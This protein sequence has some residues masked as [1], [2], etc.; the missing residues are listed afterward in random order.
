MLRLSLLVVLLAVPA[1]A[2]V[3]HDFQSWALFAGQ[4]NFNSS[5]RWYFEAQP[6]FGSNSTRLERLLVRPA[7]GLQ[8]NTF[9][10]LWAGYA[11]TP[12][13][14][15]S[16]G[17]EHRPFQQL[18]AEHPLGPVMLIN[19]TRFEQRFVEGV[20]APTIRL[21]HLLRAV[22]RFDGPTG[23]GLAASEEL[24]V[25]FNGPVSGFDQNRVFLGLNWKIG[26]L[27]L[28]LGYLNN[29]VRRSAP[30]PTGMNHTILLMLLYTVAPPS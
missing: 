13:F 10:S 20:N 11:W 23:L 16:F 30:A 4:G 27:Q 1:S 9:F 21:R 3:T 7:V 19:R 28:E 12:L 15:P 25:N 8:L 29:V 5:V 22:W 18:L 26:G 17:N 14:S 2:Q 24:F 6:R